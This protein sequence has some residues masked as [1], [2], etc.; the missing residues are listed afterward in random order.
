VQHGEVSFF[1]RLFRIAPAGPPTDFAR[2]VRALRAGRLDDAWAAFERA[3]DV[4]ADAP[5]RAL[6]CNQR[7]LVLL[8]RGDRRAAAGE[9]ARALETDAACVPAIVNVGNVHLEA[10]EPE[11]AIA[12][13][14]AA[15]ALD[16]DYPEAHHNLG[17]AFRRLGRRRE[18]VR[19]LRRA[20]V[21]ELRRKR[22]R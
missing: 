17:V 20:T 15:I 1:A 3:L 19:A 13:F 21:L 12:Q 9:L 10:G 11:R 2:G 6:V 18:A 22:R 4:A 7:A 14:E 8:A 5:A 16:P